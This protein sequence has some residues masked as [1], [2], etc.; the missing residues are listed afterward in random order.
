MSTNHTDETTARRVTTSRDYLD[1]LRGRRQHPAFRRGTFEWLPDNSPAIA[2]YWRTW[3]QD[4]VLAIHNLS[5]QAQP[6][7]LTE[8]PQGWIDLLASSRLAHCATLQ[9]YQFLWLAAM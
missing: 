7:E 4:R 6:I 8:P 1:S 2:A 5:D 3:D 9:P